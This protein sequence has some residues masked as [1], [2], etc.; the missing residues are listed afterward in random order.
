MGSFRFVGYAIVSGDGMLAAADGVMPS[1]LKFAGDQR[2]FEAGLDDADLIVHGRNSHENQPRSAERRRLILTRAVVQPVQSPD[3]PRAT[4]W[5]PAHATFEDAA[6]AAGVDQGKVAPIGGTDVFSMF[7]DRYDAFWLSQA[8][9]VRLPG[10][11]PVFHGVPHQ[12]PQ[13]ILRVHGLKPGDPIVLDAKH[14]VTVVGWTR[15]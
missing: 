10:G 6:A 4:L 5:N 3:D 2:F 1:S 13:E 11:V 8:P 9:H 12:S 14:D 7:L 15:A